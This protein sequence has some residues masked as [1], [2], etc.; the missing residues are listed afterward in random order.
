MEK[1]KPCPFCGDRDTYLHKAQGAFGA[2][3]Y[4][5]GC[6]LEAP[7]ETGVTDEQAVTYWQTREWSATTSNML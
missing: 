1:L 5:K 4:C 2:H 6:G 3:V 7:T